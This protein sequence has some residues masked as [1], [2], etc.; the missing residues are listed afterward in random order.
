MT[1]SAMLVQWEEAICAA[2]AGTV[3]LSGRDNKSNIT[4]LE[5]NT[6]VGLAA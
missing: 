2:M 1:F 6:P 5:Q 4:S 3:L